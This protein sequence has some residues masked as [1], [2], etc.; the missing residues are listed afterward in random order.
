MAMAHVSVNLVE[1]TYA[2][3]EYC[4]HTVKLF[5]ESE[6]LSARHQHK[7]YRI[8]LIEAPSITACKAMR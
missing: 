3:I 1:V 2:G 8:L 6:S 7:L 4:G 5:I